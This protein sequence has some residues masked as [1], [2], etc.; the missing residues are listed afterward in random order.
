MRVYQEKQDPAMHTLELMPVNKR[1]VLLTAEKMQRVLI[2][3]LLKIQQSSDI[4]PY[5]ELFDRKHMIELRC[6]DCGEEAANWVTKCVHSRIF[7][8]PQKKCTA[9]FRSFNKPLAFIT[10]HF[11]FSLFVHETQNHECS[12][13][14]CYICT[15]ALKSL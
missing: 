3:D 13:L 9:A 12:L 11:L 8:V 7:I 1:T 6:L 15:I 2:L 14:S 10:Y 5:F 4:V